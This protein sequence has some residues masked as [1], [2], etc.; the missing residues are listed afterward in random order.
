MN[1]NDIVCVFLYV[2]VHS[3]ACVRVS[4]LEEECV[5][6]DMSILVYFDG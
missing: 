3:G 2:D 5:A 6:I 1:R 4:G